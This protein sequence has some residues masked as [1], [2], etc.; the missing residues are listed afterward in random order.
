MAYNFEF[1]KID[2]KD[3]AYVLGLLFADGCI[4]N[5]NTIRISLVD[6]QLIEDIHKKFSF[7]NLGKFDYSIYNK[8]SKIQYS[9]TKKSGYLLRH[10]TKLGL[11]KRKSTENSYR[12]HIPVLHKDLYSHFIRGYFDGNGSISIP[13]ARPNLRRVEI[14]SSS[15]T[16]IEDLILL[17]KGNN[18]SIPIYRK[19][20]NTNSILYLIEWVKVED[21][22][23]FGKFIYQDADLKL[24]RKFILFKDFKLINRTDSNPKCPKCKN[25]L[26]KAGSRANSKEVL[27]R[28]KCKNCKRAFSYRPDQLKSDELLE[29]PKVLDTQMC[30]LI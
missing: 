13:K 27:M 29:T 11:L 26:C 16:L 10:L 14:C 25:N 1:E 15:K 2:T 23:K 17:L 12:L 20:D 7:F 9:L 5:L 3:K 8:N 18:I 24:D 6:K 22:I 30:Y 4:T 19:K 21:I 28:F